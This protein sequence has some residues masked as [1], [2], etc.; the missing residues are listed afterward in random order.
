[1]ATPAAF[2]AWYALVKALKLEG[3]VL[4]ELGRDM[5]SK[6]SLPQWPPTGAPGAL[7][8]GQLLVKLADAKLKIDDISTHT[9]YNGLDDDWWQDEGFKLVARITAAFGGGTADAAPGKVTLA[10][11][12][13]HVMGKAECDSTV[14]NPLFSAWEAH[15]AADRFEE[16]KAMIVTS[17]LFGRTLHRAVL[18]FSATVEAETVKGDYVRPRLN[19]ALAA[20]CALESKSIIKIIDGL[21][22]RSAGDFP[23]VLA[24]E[25]KTHLVSF[26]RGQLRGSF[27]KAVN[28]LLG[29][30]PGLAAGGVM[31]DCPPN[32]IAK[33][34]E[35][36]FAIL[37][38][39]LADVGPNAALRAKDVMEVWSEMDS[40]YQ[41]Y[42]R[43]YPLPS[44][45]NGRGVGAGA[46]DVLMRVL[47]P[48][49]EKW[50]TRYWRF[51]REKGA[52]DA[53]DTPKQLMFKLTRNELR[54][55]SDGYV[56]LLQDADRCRNG[57]IPL[58][59][60]RPATPSKEP[61]HAGADL[62]EHLQNIED[63]KQGRKRDRT[64]K[65]TTCDGPH[66]A[67]KCWQTFPYLNPRHPQF[68]NMKEERRRKKGGGG[69][70]GRG[71]GFESPMYGQGGMQYQQGQYQSPVGDPNQWVQSHQQQIS[72]LTPP[73]FQGI[74]GQL[75]LGASPSQWAS[76]PSGFPP[77][78]GAGQQGQQPGPQGAQGGQP[79]MRPPY[80]PIAA[81]TC[82]RCGK[83]GHIV[84]DCKDPP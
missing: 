8:K 65:C 40:N 28:L 48:V 5:H 27:G 11:L 33:A 46:V 17:T 31:S 22:A 10:M 44:G 58:A 43:F 4:S 73:P 77:P 29:S 71:G 3:D 57:A 24:V 41:Y 59:P 21:Y 35:A 6:G 79:V 20:Y 72:G 18:G 25:I 16:A 80:V 84:K 34:V 62:A 49:L 9:K 23:E 76:A 52:V 60:Q 63:K 51:L 54:Y 19:A 75:Q 83:T 55:E 66:A 12:S 45:P 67:S 50:T 7:Q 14:A 81:R 82:H 26:S 15:V 64:R 68:Q 13:G 42:G 39:L 74:P 61:Q 38:I 37:D 78:Q 30:A 1:M 69:G 53:E 56:S 47:F 2:K 70:R 32:S 36:V